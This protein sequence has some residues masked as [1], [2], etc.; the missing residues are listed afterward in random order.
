MDKRRQAAADYAKKAKFDIIFGEYDV[1][2][3]FKGIEADIKAPSRCRLCWKMRLKKTAQRAK[4]E[5][6][7]AFTTTLLVSPYQDREAIVKIGSE[8]AGEFGVTFIDS[9]WRGGFRQAQQAARE[10]DIYRQK[11]CGCTFSEKE[12]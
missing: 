7:E 6:F 9:D 4:E 11:Y 10:S 3:F 2:D 5:G 1:E 8:L 12:R